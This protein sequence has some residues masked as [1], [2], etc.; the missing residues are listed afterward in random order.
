MLHLS[1][2]SN[3]AFDGKTNLNKK[4]QRKQIRMRAEMKR[5]KG[6]YN[7]TKKK[8]LEVLENKDWMDVPTIARKVGIRPV[9]RTYTYLAHLEDLGLVKRGLDAPG[10]LH[11]QITDRGL[12]RLQWLRLQRK[13]TMRLEEL[14]APFIR[15]TERSKNT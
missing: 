13:T 6:S 11:F 7:K 1:A 8:A 15:D 2:R 5:K 12:E 4:C 3:F 10:K 14:I 9:R